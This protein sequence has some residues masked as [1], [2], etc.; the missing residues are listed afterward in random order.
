MF[1]RRYS[2]VDAVNV[3]SAIFVELDVYSASCNLRPYVEVYRP[4]LLHLRV[5]RQTT[6]VEIKSPTVKLA[7]IDTLE[8]LL[9]TCLSK[10]FPMFYTY[11]ARKEG[12]R[13]MHFKM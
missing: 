13:S 12:G 8:T 6:P 3:Y 2:Y 10:L 1:P 11:S 5:T 7:E 4:P 9:S